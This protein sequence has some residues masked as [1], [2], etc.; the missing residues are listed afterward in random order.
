MAPKRKAP[1]KT[2][3]PDENEE[4]LQE[5][6]EGSTDPKFRIHS[7]GILLTYPK[8][9]IDLEQFETVPVWSQ[10]WRYSLCHE[11]AQQDHSHLY[12]EFAKTPD[13]T[14]NVW[15][16]PIDYTEDGT[17]ILADVNCKPCRARG[18]QARRAMDR[19][20]FYAYCPYKNTHINSWTNYDPAKAYAVETEWIKCLWKTNKINDDRVLDCAAFYNCATKQLEFAA[21]QALSR[22]ATESRKEWKKR[23]LEERQAR[24]EPFRTCPPF[25]KWLNTNRENL[26]RY[27]FFWMCGGSLYG[28]SLWVKSHFKNPFIHFQGIN[29]KGYNPVV[30][31]AVIFDDVC[32]DVQMD[33]IIRDNKGIFQAGA[34]NPEV[35]TSQCNHYALNIDIE[36]KPIIILSNQDHQPKSDW[37]FAN[38]IYVE[39]VDYCYGEEDNHTW[40]QEKTEQDFFKCYS[41]NN[42][43]FETKKKLD[44][45]S[46][47][48]ENAIEKAGEKLLEKFNKAAQSKPPAKNKGINSECIIGK[49]MVQV[50][51]E[52]PFFTNTNI[53]S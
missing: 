10:V 49:E 35:Q 39:I 8:H 53:F 3:Q 11:K 27:K 47:S 15:K 12:L 37:V 13:H 9:V 51:R 38:C 6:E 4:S 52:D 43:F 44:N 14:L 28:K 32:K 50:N 24:R 18:L 48:F 1:A 16:L 34:G 22:K 45:L 17:P 25:K 23:R 26:D 46:E 2:A 33:D 42:E 29:W 19:G 5:I 31:D 21:F 40:F 7:L 30:H 20:H 41:E 36:G